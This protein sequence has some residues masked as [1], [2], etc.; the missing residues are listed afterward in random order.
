MTIKPNRKLRGT[1]FRRFASRLDTGLKHTRGGCPCCGP[2]SGYGAIGRLAQDKKAEP[3]ELSDD[4]SLAFEEVDEL[5]FIERQLE[6][7]EKQ[8]VQDLYFQELDRIAAEDR[9][10]FYADLYASEEIVDYPD[11]YSLESF[12]ADIGW[13]S[14]EDP[15]YAE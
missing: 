8:A 6:E 13:D 1:A 10:S 3:V 5:S 11:D 4:F 12:F 15:E 7:E 14:N 2:G 9:A